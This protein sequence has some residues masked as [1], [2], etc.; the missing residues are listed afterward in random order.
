MPSPPS[1]HLRPATSADK[2]FLETLFF[3]V[4]VDEFRL[5]GLPEPELK[6][7]LQLQLRAQRMGYAKDFADAKDSIIV[8]GDEAP[9]A[10]GRLLVA[11]RRDVNHLVDIA[12]VPSHRGQGIGTVLIAKL[13]DH[14]TRQGISVRL[15]VR[16]GNPAFHLYSRLGF[17]LIGGGEHLEME[18]RPGSYDADSARTGQTAGSAVE[19]HPMSQWSTLRGRKFRVMD[20]PGA[21]FPPLLLTRL[22]RIAFAASVTHSL[23]FHG[24]P[25]RILP[26]AMYSLRLCP[27]RESEA[28][29]SEDR[30]VFLVPI[31]PVGEA[32][33]YEAVFN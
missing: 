15:H 31:G 32:M 30:L 8:T 22:E 28:A 7:L 29:E 5:M 26:Q 14:S 6:A 10:I 4:H 9:N 21:E 17:R 20:V 13:L 1:V 23:I 27:E 12:L 25:D 33:Q 24:P 2:T 19:L 3:E 11:Y 16:P 18:F